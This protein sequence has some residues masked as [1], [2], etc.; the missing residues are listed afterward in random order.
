MRN[1][2][3]P[4]TKNIHKLTKNKILASKKGM[5]KSPTR[6]YEMMNS[7]WSPLPPIVSQPRFHNVADYPPK[8]KMQQSKRWSLQFLLFN[9]IK[10][11]TAR[12]QSV[13][14]WAYSKLYT[15]TILHGILGIFFR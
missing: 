11:C 4:P 15:E 14:W 12:R 9:L 3:S 7:V 1:N 5:A 2:F 8:K 13:I 10:V 6:W